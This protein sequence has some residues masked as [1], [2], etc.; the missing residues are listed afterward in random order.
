M[1]KQTQEVMLESGLMK[2][3]IVYWSGEPQCVILHSAEKSKIVQIVDDASE[4]LKKKM[5]EEWNFTDFRQY[6]QANGYACCEITN[7]IEA[8]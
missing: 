4:Y 3:S 2:V 1:S 8:T 6:L 7:E 5:G